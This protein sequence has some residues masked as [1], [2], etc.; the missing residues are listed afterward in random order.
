MAANAKKFLSY[1]EPKRGPD[2]AYRN[3]RKQNPTMSGLVLVVATFLFECVGM[4]RKLIWKNAGFA[5]LRKIRKQLE[6]YEPRVDPTV[7]PISELEAES[8]N[9]SAAEPELVSTAISPA[10]KYYSVQDYHKMYL[11][12]ELTPTA[13]A[14]AILPM[15]RRDTS[16][17]GEHSI[18]WFETKVDLILAAAAASTS[19]YKKGCPLGL[20]DGVPTAVKDEYDMDG[21]KTCLGSLNDYSSDPAPSGESIASWCVRKLEEAGAVVLGKLSMHEFGLGTF[22]PCSCSIHSL[23][24][25]S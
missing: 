11:S 17:P 5:S 1:P 4:I 16:P 15:I 18:A 22:W 3:E 19:R 21:Y 25:S 24:N 13:V 6:D 23:A 20:L 2:V 9:V 7:V 14:K 8:E 12:G 10:A